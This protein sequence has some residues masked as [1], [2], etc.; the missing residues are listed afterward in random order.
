MNFLQDY[1]PS[2]EDIQ[3][4]VEKAIKDALIGYQDVPPDMIHFKTEFYVPDFSKS[5]NASKLVYT[6]AIPITEPNGGIDSPQQPEKQVEEQKQEQ[7]KDIE[8][9]NYTRTRIINRITFPYSAHGIIIIKKSEND[10]PRWG[11]G[12]LVGPDTVLTAAHIVYDDEKPI[13]KRYPYIRF[14]PRTDGNEAPF[15]EIE[16][17]DVYAPKDYLNNGDDDYKGDVNVKNG[18]NGDNY[19]FLLLKR[20]IGLEAGYLGLYLVPST[21][22][23]PFKEISIV[24]DTGRELKEMDKGMLEQ[25]E[26]ER[27]VTEF[28]REKRLIHYEGNPSTTIQ[29]GSSIIYNDEEYEPYVVGVHISRNSASWITPEQ[30]QVFIDWKKEFMKEKLEDIFRGRDNENSIR[31]LDFTNSGIG[32]LGLNVL[33]GYGLNGLE[34]LNLMECKIDANGIEAMV[35]KSKWPNLC[36]L[37]LSSNEIGTRGCEVLAQNTTWKNLKNL[38]LKSNEIK[39]SGI[40]SLVQNKV[41]N[42][43]EV[44]NLRDSQ[45][46]DLGA[47]AIATS[48]HWKH[49]ISLDLSQNNIGKEGGSAI[50]SNTSWCKLKR[51]NLSYNR[52]SGQGIGKIAMNISWSNLQSLA[53]ADNKLGDEGAIAIGENTSWNNLDE[54]RLSDNKI[55]DKGAIGLGSNTV[56]KKL[57]I[58]DMTSNFIGDEGGVAIGGNMTWKNLQ[59]LYLGS[60]QLRSKSV[61]VMAENPTWEKLM[62]LDLKDNN[63]GEEGTMALGRNITWKNLWDLHLSQNDCGWKGAIALVRNS[64]WIHMKMVEFTAGRLTEERKNA[65]RANALINFNIIRSKKLL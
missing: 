1:T 9:N 47:I 19:A 7:E 4:I 24:G 28:N 38:S 52:I 13:R 32:N 59:A 57:R 45:A 2:Q 40:N 44:L 21:I 26:E 17:E 39:G 33:S 5:P 16:I 27:A 34:R 29:T 35:S 25:W 55:G 23:K 48:E 53:I 8:S 43:L 6:D 12:V 61:A 41:W 64:S 20:P 30:F 37:D 11:P 60:N 10:T 42:E 31:A 58:L 18:V 3:E 49:L 65:L 15:G 56:W 62:S 63:I 51:L 14:I 54:L 36:D 50:A 22:E 46:G